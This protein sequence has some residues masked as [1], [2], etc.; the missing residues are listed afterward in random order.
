MSGRTGPPAAGSGGKD[1]F[2]VGLIGLWG[3]NEHLRSK[4]YTRIWGDAEGK[5]ALEA[6]DCNFEK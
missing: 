5:Y 1:D 6:A 3:V 2:E 4:V